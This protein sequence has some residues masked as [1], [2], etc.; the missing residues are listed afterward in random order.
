MIMAVLDDLMFTSKIRS[1]AGGLGATV[2]FARSR[3]TAL[4]EMR[5]A[6]PSLVIFDLNNRRIDPLGILAAMKEDSALAA[7]RTIGYVSH[8]DSGTIDASRRAGVDEVMAR[9]A[10]VDRLAEILRSG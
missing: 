3:D 9:S 10:F 2:V 7:V 5:K 1:A 8:V 4:A 6:L